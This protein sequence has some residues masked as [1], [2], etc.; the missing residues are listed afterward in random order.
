MVKLT[1]KL[2][3]KPKITGNVILQNTKHLSSIWK[4]CK[5]LSE[6]EAFRSSNIDSTM[7]RA[8]NTALNTVL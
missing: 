1:G 2:N 8:F 5:I 7:S 3:G 4:W 6:S